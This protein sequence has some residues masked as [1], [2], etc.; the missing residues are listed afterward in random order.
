MALKNENE[1]VKC[2]PQ[3]LLYE[4]LKKAS[5]QGQLIGNLIPIIRSNGE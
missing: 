2:M 4:E 1:L 3:C 5:A